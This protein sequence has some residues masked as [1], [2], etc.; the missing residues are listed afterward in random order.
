[1]RPAPGVEKISF[2]R[3]TSAGARNETRR[4]VTRFGEAVLLAFASRPALPASTWTCKST[5]ARACRSNSLIG[6]ERRQ[7]ASRS[8]GGGTAI[9]SAPELGGSACHGTSST[10]TGLRRTCARLGYTGCF[11]NVPATTR[12]PRR[13]KPVRTDSQSPKRGSAIPKS[14]Y[15]CAVLQ[16]VAY[17]PEEGEKS[18]TSTFRPCD[19]PP[20]TPIRRPILKNKETALFQARRSYLDSGVATCRRDRV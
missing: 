17:L 8:T 15:R 7:R 12:W 10:D 16:S 3:P 11:T 1:M 14:W 2:E 13:S 20:R 4:R 19:P 5:T 6:L 9:K 18:T